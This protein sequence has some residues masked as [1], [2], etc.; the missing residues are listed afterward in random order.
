MSEKDT[1]NTDNSEHEE[2][3]ILGPSEWTPSTRPLRAQPPRRFVGLLWVRGFLILTLSLLVCIAGFNA[4]QE[5]LFWLDSPGL[6][7][8]LLR[9][10]S[11]P[12]LR[13]KAAQRL[14][15]T[16][17]KAA[18]YRASIRRSLLTELDE[19]T[20]LFSVGLLKAFAPARRDKEA[21][22]SAM[23]KR[24]QLCGHHATK[25]WRARFPKESQLA[26][27][28]LFFQLKREKDEQTR[29]QILAKIALFREQLASW[30]DTLLKM[31]TRTTSLAY[32]QTLF[33]VF[34]A[35]GPKGH[36][37]L[38]LLV[39]GLSQP[40]LRLPAFSSMSRMGRHTR[41]YLPLMLNALDKEPNVLEQRRMIDALERLGVHAQPAFVYL[42]K[43]LSLQDPLHVQAALTL[44]ALSPKTEAKRLLPFLRRAWK[45]SWRWWWRHRC[46]RVMIQM[47]PYAP[48]HARAVLSLRQRDPHPRVQKELARASTFLPTSTYLIFS[49]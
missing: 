26:L 44:A 25:L 4:L 39:K 28:G 14:S 3:H 36:K 49:T 5:G 45:Q 40:S 9:W 12:T 16:P 10:G 7:A 23:W 31:Y 33:H 11:T 17:Q 43:K 2:E 19:Q 6:H 8:W 29:L 48:Q 13:R 47:L 1:A 20:C 22:L 46:A 41:P 35:A 24:H 15:L 18:P 21:L 42:H 30:M 34:G 38:P 37:A 27:K 32:K